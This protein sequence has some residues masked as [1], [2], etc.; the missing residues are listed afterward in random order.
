MHAS[1]RR[2]VRFAR[3]LIC[4]AD[5]LISGLTRPADSLTRVLSVLIESLT[6]RTGECRYM[7]VVPES[8]MEEEGS[9]A[10]PSAWVHRVAARVHRV[11][12]W[13]HRVAAE[14]VSEAGGAHGGLPALPA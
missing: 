13:V 9:E 4:S 12:A 6:Q 11:A 3:L 10:G 14:E 5:Q 2:R 7:K 1:V 8:T